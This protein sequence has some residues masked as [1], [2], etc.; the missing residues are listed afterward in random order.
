M[1]SN[2]S[3]NLKRPVSVK[4]V[5]YAFVII[6]VLL[7]PQFLNVIYPNNEYLTLITDGKGWYMY[8]GFLLLIFGILD[9]KHL[10]NKKD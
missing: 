6:I 3:N 8:I 2:E 7:G 5:I 1:T 10:I 4:T 9:F